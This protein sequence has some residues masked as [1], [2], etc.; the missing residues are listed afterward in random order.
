MPQSM[1]IGG[2]NPTPGDQLPKWL[3]TVG[4][5][6][7]GNVT[8]LGQAVILNQPEDDPEWSPARADGANSTRVT[9]VVIQ[10]DEDHT[11]EGDFLR[12]R[13]APG[14]VTLS[15]AQWAQVTD[16][17]AALNPGNPY[18]LSDT[19]AGNITQTAPTASN[20]YVV[21]VGWAI[22]STELMVQIGTPIKN[23]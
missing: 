9:G 4:G 18:F 11:A 21:V 13:Y 22:S 7:D 6:N 15:E 19:T 23:P 12:L 10:I 8:K 17:A 2:S 14:I 5:K 16:D 20:H 1:I 3:G